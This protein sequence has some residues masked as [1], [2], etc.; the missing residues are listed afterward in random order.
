MNRYGATVMRHWSRFLPRAYAEIRNPGAFFA[1]LGEQIAWQ[2]DELANELAGDD[3]PGEGYLAKV[4]RLTAARRQAED[5]VMHDY[6]MLTP[7]DDG[8]EDD[9]PPVTG[10]R[11]M[12]VDHHHPS[13]PEVNAEQ[14][15]RISDIEAG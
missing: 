3:P 1:I 6:G 4:R 9:E 15:E 13:W 5:T 2:I 14:R 12:V 10:E 8:D 7:E 11:P